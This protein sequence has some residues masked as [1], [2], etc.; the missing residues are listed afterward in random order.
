MDFQSNFIE[1]VNEKGILSYFS[2][3]EGR[4]FHRFERLVTKL[5][6]LYCESQGK[7]FLTG[8]RINRVFRADGFAP[9]G[10][11][12]LIGPT[13]VEIKFG[14]PARENLERTFRNILSFGSFETVL[15]VTGV[16]LL[17]TR[18]Q[19]LEKE[20]KSILEKQNEAGNQIQFKV[21]DS[22]KIIELLKK[23]A[24]FIS[25]LIP[26]VTEL[27][28]DNVVKKSVDVDPLE[29]KKDRDKHFE[30]LKSAYVDNELTLILGAGVSLKAGVPDWKSLVSS[31]LT[32]LIGAKLPDALGTSEEEKRAI[33]EYIQ[34]VNE[35]SPLLE[36]RYIRNGLGENF[37]KIVSKYLY[38]D[39]PED[40]GTSKTLE[41][42]AKVCI[43]PRDGPGIRAIITYNF[44]N[45]AEKN[46]EALGIKNRSIYRDNDSASQDEIGVYHVHGFLPQN[47]EQY[48]DMSES[49]LIFSEEGYHTVFQEPYSWSNLV[50]LNFL[51]ESTCLLVGLSVTD[52]NLRRLL[53][54][55]AKKGKSAKHYVFQK[56]FEFTKRKKKSTTIRNE[57]SQTF[58]SVHHQLQ[59][60]LFNE[61]GLN[62]IW[63]E[64]YDRDIP[65]ILNDLKK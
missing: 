17:K 13:V 14:L 22:D 51:R 11:D 47:V 1:E 18:R 39:L 30:N 48:D 10:I 7:R 23:Y 57:V 31:L 20:I 28:V 33:A 52:P 35:G 37:Q 59:E 32:D 9:D 27:A 3:S 41:A 45:L 12:E 46:L 24:E 58:M 6:G 56:R 49:L 62:I 55:A 25:D 15:L 54:I 8:L 29:W 19:Q 40:G 21:W 64:D 63:V 53:D 5:I 60:T 36:T 34:K 50:Q 65:R 42:I 26:E 38:R 43:P 2:P 61:L 44:D 16:K 4:N